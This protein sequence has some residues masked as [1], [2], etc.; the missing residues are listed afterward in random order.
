MLTLNSFIFIICKRLFFFLSYSE[1]LWLDKCNWL[2]FH[3]WFYLNVSVFKWLSKNKSLFFIIIIVDILSYRF[4]ISIQNLFARLF[5][6]KNYYYNF[7]V[8][9]IKI[10]FFSSLC[11]VVRFI[12]RKNV[13][14]NYFMFELIYFICIPF[15]SMLSVDRVYSK[16]CIEKKMYVYRLEVT[17]K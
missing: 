15:I 3:F 11:C 5:I 16:C 1:T 12:L 7:L 13:C 14:I 6:I 9:W 4:I 17:K 2:L 8:Q 10:F